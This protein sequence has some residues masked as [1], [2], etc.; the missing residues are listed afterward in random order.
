MKWDSKATVLFALS[1][2]CIHAQNIQPTAF[3]PTPLEWF[4]GQNTSHVVWSNQVGRL[5]SKDA[6]AV[7]TALVVEDMAQPPDRMRGVRIDLSDQ[8]GQD[9]VYLGEETLAAF[10]AALDQI[11]R[12]A[13]RGCEWNTGGTCPPHASWA[14]HSFGMVTGSPRYIHLQRRTTLPQTHLGCS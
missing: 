14:H 11:G 13:A 12:D 1:A 9:H 6:R 5:E 8:D 10:K 3:R 7:I 4:A 2:T